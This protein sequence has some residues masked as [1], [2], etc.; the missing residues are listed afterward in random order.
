MLQNNQKF[1]RCPIVVK[2]DDGTTLKI[3]E[4]AKVPFEDFI[5]LDIYDAKNNRIGS[6]SF[7]GSQVSFLITVK[8]SE[9]EIRVVYRDE[10]GN[11]VYEEKESGR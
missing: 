5:F 8:R 7:D 11:K 1:V 4:L 9:K 6:Y 3:I 10:K 2:R